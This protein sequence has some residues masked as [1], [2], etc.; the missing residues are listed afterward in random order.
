MKRVNYFEVQLLG[1]DDFRAEQ[2]YHREKRKMHNRFLH[3]WGVVSGLQVSVADGALRVEPGLALDCEGNEVL[4][5]APMACR[6]PQSRTSAYLTVLY[7][8]RETDPAPAP[9]TG[10]TDPVQ[11]TRIDETFQ[12]GFEPED[13]CVAC[14]PVRSPGCGRNHAVTL[15]K[16]AFTRAGWRVDRRFK[17]PRV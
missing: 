6:L 2:R 4:V 15:A 13:P 1:L 7:V 14:G 10:D 8:E 11:H 5:P 3:G 9:G 16:L 12:L 17:A